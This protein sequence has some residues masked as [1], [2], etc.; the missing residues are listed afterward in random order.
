MKHEQELKIQAWLDGEMSNHEAA[1]IADWVS[2]D[3]EAGELAA[4]LGT[5][6]KTMTE[7]EVDGPRSRR[8]SILLEQD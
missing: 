7:N 4:E 5:V 2:R 6:R 1:R 8:A 3:A